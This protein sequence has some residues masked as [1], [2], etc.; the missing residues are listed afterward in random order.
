MFP[1]L[2]S[3]NRFLELQQKAAVP[4]MLFLKNECMGKSHRIFIYSTR[5]KVCRNQRIHNHKVFKG[6]AER[7]KSSMG[8]FYGFKLHLIVNEKG[9]LLSFYLSKGNVDD[10]NINII[11]KMTKDI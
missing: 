1:K 8:W 2:V 9:E 10:R 3:Y 11:K 6:I 5:L 4:F 7:G